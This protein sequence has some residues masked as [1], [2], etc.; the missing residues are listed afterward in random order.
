MAVWLRDT[1]D[2]FRPET[3]VADFGGLAT[4]VWETLAAEHDLVAIPAEK[5]EKHDFIELFNGDLRANR[6][7]LRRG[8]P[9]A[10][11]MLN[12]RWDELTVGR[13]KRRESDQTPND[14]C[15]AALYAWR[16]ANHR[17]YRPGAP[18]PPDGSDAWWAEYRR[19][20]RAAAEREAARRRGHETEFTGM[21][22][23]WWGN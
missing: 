11:E 15:D 22:R 6:V 8:S 19:N 4:K 5:K 9:L 17:R 1:R 23:D 10:D 18:R 20:Q 16:W 12:H 14:L 2:A 7:W 3:I 13:E 21:D